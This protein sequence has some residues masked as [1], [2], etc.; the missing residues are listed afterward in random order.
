MAPVTVFKLL[1]LIRER[2]IKIT[3][4]D[5]AESEMYAIKFEN[6]TKAMITINPINT[7]E[8]LVFAPE[9]IFKEDL[10]KDPEHGI[11]ATNPHP[12]VDRPK[13][14]VSRLLSILSPHLE[15]RDFPMES[16]SIRQSKA[17]ASEV[18]I[19]GTRLSPIN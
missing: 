15:A 10:V 5:N 9:F 11:P 8:A 17:N 14:S 2:P 1:I 19:S 18:S 13:E 6:E 7:L 12:K 3:K 16:P 4:V